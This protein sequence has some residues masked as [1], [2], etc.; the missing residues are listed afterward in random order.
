M[1]E[2]PKTPEAP[3]PN[4]LRCQTGICH[5]TEDYDGRPFPDLEIES[6]PCPIPACGD[7]RMT[8]RC[9]GLTR[10]GE[11]CPNPVKPGAGCRFHPKDGSK[12]K[13]SGKVRSV[14]GTREKKAK[15]SRNLPS[16][17]R[18]RR[19]KDGKPPAGRYVASH[20]R[21]AYETARDD[22]EAQGAFVH[23]IA[24]F[25]ARLD[26]LQRML[27]TTESPAAWRRLGAQLSLIHI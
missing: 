20:L 1:D 9:G 18:P 15:G 4:L 11:R 14:L 2:T 3:L 21:E 19:P 10:T 17:G 6:F 24:L 16:N 27:E 23:E 13:T 22:K 7:G 5:Y 12:P 25:R 26:E 8:V